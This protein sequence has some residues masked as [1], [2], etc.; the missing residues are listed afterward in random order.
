ML[1]LSRFRIIAI[2]FSLFLMSACSNISSVEENISDS[3][4]DKFRVVGYF[5][6]YRIS[7]TDNS[8]AENLT[9]II[10]FSIEPE[11][12]GSLD[13]SRLNS[14]VYFKLNALKKMNP[15]LRVYIAVGGWGRSEHFG[16]MATNSTA[17]ADFIAN[18]SELCRTAGFSGADYDWEFP[19]NAVENEAYGVLLTET[20]AEFNK[21]NLQLSVALNVNQNLTSKAYSALHCINIMSYDHS[22]RHSTYEQS[23]SDVNNFIARGISA[24]KLCLGIPFYGREITNFSNAW[25]YKNIIDTYAPGPGEDVV[26]G[27]FFNGITTV[28]KK[29]EFALMQKLQG[30]MIWEIG[31][32]AM[33]EYALLNA[34]NEEIEQVE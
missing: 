22:G 13:L 7:E 34:I 3:G 6:D 20:R 14:D 2:F 21:H 12:D 31:Q 9:D 32:D 25:S 24:D 17:R 11:P 18:L 8:V 10:Y 30:V 5:P 15:D 1:I 28:R 16:E 26:D 4:T 29:T 23:V 27:I 33:G 19:A